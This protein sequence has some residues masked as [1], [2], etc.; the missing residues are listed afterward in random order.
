MKHLTFKVQITQFHIAHLKTAKT[1]AIEQAL[2]CSGS[3]FI[4]LDLKGKDDKRNEKIRAVTLADMEGLKKV[5]DSS[6]LF[7]SEYLDEMISD[8]L[9]PG[10]RKGGSLM[11]RPLTTPE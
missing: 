9:K 4:A 8:P 6:Q 10:E 5:V 1:A 2:D 7:P 3:F 11:T